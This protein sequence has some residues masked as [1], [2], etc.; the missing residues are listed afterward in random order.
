MHTVLLGLESW[1]NTRGDAQP[2]SGAGPGAGPRRRQMS[3]WDRCCRTA[4]ALSSCGGSDCCLLRAD[5]A[6]RR[7]A[8]RGV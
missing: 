4:A 5:T 8:T 7:N 2:L 3:S 1:R 6:E